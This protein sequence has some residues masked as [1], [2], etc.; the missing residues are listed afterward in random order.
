MRPGSGRCGAW[1]QPALACVLGQ[2]PREL[3]RLEPA[4]ELGG[5]LVPAHGLAMHGV[6]EPL[7]HHLE[8]RH[9][10]LERVVGVPREDVRRRRRT[11][12]TKALEH[13]I[14]QPLSGYRRDR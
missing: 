12:A 11:T 14:P 1:L 3:A 10:A 4:L 6:L 7:D 13:A 5:L 9:A 2:G 8:V